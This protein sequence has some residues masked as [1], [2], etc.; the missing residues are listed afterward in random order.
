MHV[1]TLALRPVALGLL[2]VGMIGGNAAYAASA[3]SVLITVDGHQQQISSHSGT[4]AGVLADAHLRVGAHDLLA[5]SKTTAMSDRTQ[6]VLR[7]GREMAVTVDGLERNVWVTALSVDEALS[8][9]GVRAPGVLV[10]AER[11]REIPLK[12]FSLDVRTRKTISLLDG[13]KLRRYV[14]NAVAVGDLLREM[15]VPLRK[16]DK[17][18][19][20]ATAPV[21]DGLVMSI[22]R[23]DGAR[24]SED[25]A[26]A[27]A[28]VRTADSTMYVGTS[29]VV[30]P[31]SVGIVHRV[32]ALTY[33]NHKLSSRKLVSSTKTADPVTKLIRYGTK[34]RPYVAHT[35]SG[36][37]GLNWGALARCESGGNPRAVSRNGTYRGLYQFSMSTWHGVGG[38]GDPIDASSS[39]QTYRA[40]LLYKRSGRGAWPTCG[41]Y[42]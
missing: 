1:S 37:S 20:P 13:G 41:R 25:H 17:L 19:L 32:Y 22:T 10:S 39:E 11:S 15:K 35:V 23:M 18:S 12:G 38:S 42:L 14:T 34:R 16:Q 7:H 27:F 33:V 21:R 8:Q 6:I 24:V 26:I 30:R 40:K 28:V 29:K 36:T 2:I 9:L 31:G 3:R 5:P 4:V